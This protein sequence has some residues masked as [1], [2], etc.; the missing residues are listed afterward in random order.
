M[1]KLRG[2]VLGSFVADAIS[3]GPHWIY[4]TEDIQAQFAPINGL[5]SPGTT[6]HVGKEKGDF[7]HYGDQTLMLFQYMKLNKR[8]DKES[9]YKC[10][11]EYMGTYKGYIDHA[12]KETLKNLE[13]DMLTGSHSSE[14][15]GFARSAPVIYMYQTEK[16]SGISEAVLQTQLT[17]NQPVLLERS[18]FLSKLIYKALK[19]EAPSDAIINLKKTV[20][21]TILDDIEFARNML[22]YDTTYAMKQIGQSCDSDYAF[23]A[24][25]YFVMKYEDDFERA[26]IEN[27]YAGGDSAARGMVIGAILGAHLGEEKIP[28]NW[29]ASMNHLKDIENL[30]MA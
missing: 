25:L 3:L 8:I 9:F 28:I 26:L 12:T 13:S 22:P 15:G 16:N 23:P 21:K 6:Y 17:H 14:L 11:K 24:V 20:S 10:F 27:C 7:T 1:S 29:L 2:M 30:L 19:G 4:S 18:E 5:T